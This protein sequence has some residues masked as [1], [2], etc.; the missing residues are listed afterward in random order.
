MG[1]VVG[2]KK[3][4]AGGITAVVLIAIA[5]AVFVFAFTKHSGGGGGG[6]AGNANNNNNSNSNAAIKNAVRAVCSSTSYRET[7]ETSLSQ[8]NTTDPKELLK[9]AMEVA[10]RGVGDLLANSTLLRRAAEDAA[11]RDALYVC[12][13]VFDLAVDEMRRSLEKVG[14]LELSKMSEYAG[15]VRTWL[16]AVVTNQETCIDAFQNTT[17]D[18]GKKMENLMKTVREMSSNCLAIVTQMSDLASQLEIGGVRRKMMSDEPPRGWRRRLLEAD[19]TPDAVVALDGSARF[20]SI[21][22]AISAAPE[23][24]ARPFVIHVKEG[25]YAETVVVPKKKDNIVLIGDGPE[26]TRITGNLNFAAGVKTFVTATVAVNARDFFA[27]DIAVENTAGPEGHQ[28]VA[29]RVSGDRA[30]FYNVHID[31]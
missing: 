24:N 7:C 16:S 4:L 15:D 12:E 18:V 20:S 29:L 27:R 3:I 23:M 8:V 6:D 21:N 5:V 11:T 14:E 9:Y 19:R 31:G 25:L 1:G 13:D 28:A 22:D 10:L 2:S 30:V 17:G 26:K